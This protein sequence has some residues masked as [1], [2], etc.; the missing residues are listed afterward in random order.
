MSS[1]PKL[2]LL[3]AYALIY[4]AYFAFSKNPRYNSKGLN[5]S[6]ILGFTNSLVE[7]LNK[8]KPSHIAVVFDTAAPTTR[9]VDFS[10]YKANREAQPEDITLSIPYIQKII[11]GFHI[12]VLYSDGYEAD[13]VIGTLAKE[14]EKNGFVTFMMTPDKDFG[15]LVTDKIFIY[16]PARFGNESEVLGIKEVCQKF[17]IDNP[18]QVIDILG[19]MGDAVD[20]IPGIPGVGE[21]TAKLLIKEF[22]SV[23]NLLNN[24][25]KLKGKL[26]EKVE[27]NK[28]KALMSKSLATIITDVPIEFNERALRLDEPDKD[29]LREVFAELEFRTIGKRIL[30]EEITPPSSNNQMSLFNT[31]TEVAANVIA[32]E[33]LTGAPSYATYLTTPHDYFLIEEIEKIKDFVQEL[34][35]QS[36]FAFDTETT[37]LNVN[38]CELVGMSFS[39]KAGE[40]FYVPVPEEK[41]KAKEILA[42]FKPVFENPGTEK[43]AQNLKYDL[44]VLLLNGIEVK[45][46]LFDTMLAHYLIQPDMKHNLTF[47]SEN[48]LNYS[49]IPIESL[50]GKR[51][52]GQLN[53]KDVPL[54]LIKEY[55]AEDADI[56][57]QLKE[58]FHPMLKETNTIE[59]F[60]EIEIPLIPVLAS[61]E[62]EGINLDILTLN[63]FSG[64]L[65]TRIKAIEKE[66]YSMAGTEFNLSSPRQLGDILFDVL[67]IDGKGKK[68]RTG[69]HSTGEEILIKLVN[70]HPIIPKILEYRTLQKLKSTYVDS[71]PLMVNPKTGKI[72]TNY[73]QAVAATGRLSSN[74]P[75]LQNIPIR[76]EEGREVRKAFIPSKGNIL[77][78]ADYSQIELRI[79][80]ELSKD[81]SMTEAFMNNL[82]IHASTAAKI[83]GV[84]LEEVSKDMRRNAKTVNFGIIYGISAFGLSERLGIPR[85][86][87]AGIIDQYF[88][89]F[90]DIKKYMNDSINFAREHGYVET[91]K[92]RRRYLKDI[93]SRNAVVR[94]FAE[95]NAIN[96][97]IQGS[98]A[99]MIKIA[100]INIHNE[101]E[102]REFKS[103]MVLQVHDELVFDIVP[104]ELNTVKQI[105][106]EK[107]RTAINLQV[108]VV[109]EMGTGY[110]WL[111]AH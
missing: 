39:W 73:N 88:L 91:I 8:E 105:V 55:A 54:E 53:M 76:S 87:A 83:Y 77:L 18:L 65:N 45:G 28:D 35:K 98:A 42:V 80:A 63:E 43:I 50:I 12:P 57:F 59:L 31:E 101:F 38:D 19:L 30:G 75:N 37:G 100:M 81:S 94:G 41:E 5:T 25:D 89:K 26:R 6:A 66:V 32:T 90:P 107:M 86:E 16:K 93:N 47:L 110:N 111:D 46:K 7:V 51:G 103:K 34:E 14:A 106:E 58:T 62:K 13:D 11:Q 102:K 3:D 27:L 22:G 67:Q 17:E 71:L 33:E 74:N 20:N 99:D 64:Y 48:Y 29:A 97:P 23:E 96:A 95:R 60:E 61:M 104:E 79:I 36:S 9:H 52:K 1:P 78:S 70:K 44:T 49:P 85:S 69:Q 24:T 10:E 56:A 92:G 15:Q 21:K 68:T 84:P 40:A 109:V 2:F 108:P 72:H 82:D 4:R